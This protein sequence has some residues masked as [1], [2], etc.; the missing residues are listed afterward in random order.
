MFFDFDAIYNETQGA[1]FASGKKRYYSSA[2]SGLTTAE[3][4]GKSVVRAVVRGAE[5]DHS[6]KI[7]FDEQGGLYDYSCD[8]DAF[9]LE[10]GPC[11]HIV[12]A[13]LSLEERL[14]VA[15]RK[16]GERRSDAGAMN[17]VSE[18]NKL[19]RR[20]HMG[21]LPVML[22]PELNI[23]GGTATLR[24]T[25]GRRKMYNLR[26]IPDFV[27]RMQ[28][29]ELRRYGVELELFH[30]REAFSEESRPIVDFLVRCYLDRRDE[31]VNCLRYKDELTLSGADLDEFMSLSEGRAIRLGRSELVMVAPL[32]EPFPLKVKVGR[33]SG[34]FNVTLGARDLVM[35]RGRNYCYPILGSKIYRLDRSFE[36]EAGPFMA[37]VNLRGALYVAES[38]MS[39]FY[40]SV[41]CRVNACLELECEEGLDL[42]VYE[43]APL[44]VKMYV[45][46][47]GG[48]MELE[49]K[50]AYDDRQIDLLGDYPSGDFV[51]DWE[52]ENAVRGI[53]AK[54][55]PRY[56]VLTLSD[57][58]EIFAFL[59][60]GV[61]DL[62]PYAEIFLEGEG[63]RSRILRPPHVRV[64]V[65]LSG[66][67]LSL[68]LAAD[69]YTFDELMS[70]L[71]AYRDK[72]R[73]V[74]L[75]A[76]FVSLDDS[77]IEALGNLLD[78]AKVT[79][80]GLELPRY[81]APYVNSELKDNFFTLSRDSA[82]KG[83]IKSLE[84]AE[85]ADIDVPEGLAGV[86]RNYQK[87]GYRW[88][89]TLREN[90]FGGI[91]ADDMGLGKSLQIIALLSEKKSCALI[92][93][94]TTLMLNWV[95]EIAKFAP[96]LTAAAVMGTPEERKATI[97]S[98]GERDVTITSYDLL[99]RD[100]ELYE[101]R[102]FD[103][104]FADEA[105]FIKN[106]DTRNAMAVK[107]IRAKYRFALTGTP[108]ENNLGELWS[109][110]DFVMP[111][112]LGG[113][114][115][116]RDKYELGVVRGESA[117]AERLGRV[118]KPFI[119]RRLKA[120]VLKEL[121]PKTE[122]VITAPLEGEQKE[123][124]AAGLALVRES[125]R[126]TAEPN[127]VAVLAMLTRLRQI[128]C[129]PRLVEP[130]Y[131]GNSAKADACLE[132]I[133]RAVSGGHRVLLFSQ[134][135]SMLDILRVSLA[136]RGIT[137]YV[138]KG[139][140]PKAERIRLIDRFNSGDVGAFLIS[141][142]A[143]GTGVNLTGADVV[144]HYDPW[145]NESV[146][147]QATDRAYRMGQKRSVQVYKLVVGGSLEEKIMELQRRKKE[148]SSSIVGSAN[149]IKEI[150][151]L[152]S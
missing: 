47:C 113:Y 65:R 49:V 105:Q 104:A 92:V 69:G 21:D 2:V 19:R 139:D 123:M 1:A 133:E 48:E 110:F 86:M 131:T 125:M 28:T 11:K 64:G 127:R 17:L 84:S 107:K 45:H 96:S 32:G 112:Y 9:S 134:F 137:H 93:C 66:N 34:G 73:Y 58:D 27:A 67:L 23:D 148:L 118:V 98:A 7:V 52:A 56:P 38:D 87:T 13:A 94:P 14:P 124:Y 111:G 115:E 85:N 121:P 100:I 72:R 120:D 147:D 90:G 20:S 6:V 138:L 135:T 30:V 42:S 70:I 10:T 103:Y 40:S 82:F 4:G 44:S 55:F 143:G 149:G 31:G 108:I 54:Y 146:M 24:F 8:C 16:A 142:K 114:G 150:L 68:D 36:E 78:A 122:T 117:A 41:L 119:L 62:T 151:E 97:L 18:Y 63:G 76:G 59:D 43:A 128:C 61:R 79:E 15:A 109:I 71:K 91:L 33:A 136:R 106:P 5:K 144:V 29:G 46:S 75:G 60:G 99:R 130:G 22:V 88:L 126:G 80:T 39:A 141:L 81:Y 129:D 51:R 95:G 37:A 102:E 25:I 140:T 12:A 83:L 50:A 57:D 145:W 89:R 3:E 35:P 74:R 132:L 116:F 26:D 152:L 53:L 77:S 101:G